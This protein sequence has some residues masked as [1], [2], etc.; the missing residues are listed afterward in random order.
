MNK[1]LIEK[2][3]EKWLESKRIEVSGDSSY[4]FQDAFISGA[5]WDRNSLIKEL[6]E[7][8]EKDNGGIDDGY[9]NRKSLLSKLD[10]LE[11]EKQ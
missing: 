4:L 7:L 11:G 3:F 10:L 5:T 8:I 2:A 1:A 6:R 9:V